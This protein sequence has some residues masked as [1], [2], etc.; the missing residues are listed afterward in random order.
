MSPS[1]LLKRVE[2]VVD[3]MVWFGTSLPVV[4]VG[5]HDARN[6]DSGANQAL[7]VPKEAM[8]YSYYAYYPIIPPLVQGPHR[9]I[10]IRSI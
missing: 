4:N 9:N 7:L 3:M 1:F 5:S 6:S 8:L 2:D 10:W